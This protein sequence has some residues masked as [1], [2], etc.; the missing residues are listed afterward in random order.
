MAESKFLRFQDLDRDGLI[1]VCDDIIQAEE[2][3]CKAPCTPNPFAVIP[4]WKQR[5]GTTSRM[6]EKYC[7][8]E[9]TKTTPFTTL[10]TAEAIEEAQDGDESKSISV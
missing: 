9:Y 8:Y 7:V 6:N 3:P 1:D 2:V 10:A 5:D 4:D